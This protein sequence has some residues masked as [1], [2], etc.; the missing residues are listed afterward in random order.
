VA[1]GASNI[2]YP[3]RI[4]S[5][6]LPIHVNGTKV[7]RLFRLLLHFLFAHGVWKLE[8]DLNLQG[9]VL[10]DQT[11]QIGEEKGDILLSS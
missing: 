7:D 3:R 9:L 2:S 5:S 8:F 6:E 1:P 4:L 10:P 11:L